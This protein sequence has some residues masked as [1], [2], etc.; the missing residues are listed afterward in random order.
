MTLSTKQWRCKGNHVSGSTLTPYSTEVC[1]ARTFW[2]QGRGSVPL[3]L[4]SNVESLCFSWML[5]VE[6]KEF[7]HE[8]HVKMKHG[9]TPN[10][11]VFWGSPLCQL[12]CQ[13]KIL[14]KISSFTWL[15]LE[16]TKKILKS[17]CETE[18]LSI[19]ILTLLNCKMGFTTGANFPRGWTPKLKLHVF[20]FTG[21]VFLKQS[22]TT[23]LITH[24][25][26][27]SNEIK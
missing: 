5:I 17:Q 25:N 18:I 21:D 14:H 1:V 9:T 6:P 19:W 27:K 3:D 11:E 8:K 2:K 4:H 12:I 10:F 16:K 23:T 24:D 22:T 7:L 15:S 20:P 13:D 26:Q